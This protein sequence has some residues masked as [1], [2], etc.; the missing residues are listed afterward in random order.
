[1][2]GGTKLRQVSHFTAHH[3]FRI[4][5]FVCSPV[6][7]PIPRNCYTYLFYFSIEG[8]EWSKFNDEIGSPG[9]SDG[10][11]QEDFVGAEKE[12]SK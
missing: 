12:T 1:L 3:L 8:N 10:V 6:A 11:K 2:E 5:V 7:N 9:L 4:I